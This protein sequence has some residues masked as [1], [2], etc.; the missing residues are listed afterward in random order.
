MA[1]HVRP[2]TVTRGIEV[3]LVMLLVAIAVMFGLYFTQVDTTFNPAAL[4]SSD[5]FYAT[6]LTSELRDSR[7]PAV[8]IDVRD[9]RPPGSD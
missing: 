2:A 5:P 7:P 9:S 3:G 1:V 6:Q 8:L 4:G